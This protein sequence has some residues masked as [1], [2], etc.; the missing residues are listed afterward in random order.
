[1]SEITGP[2]GGEGRGVGGRANRDWALFEK[3]IYF[4]HG[5]ALKAN[6]RQLELVVVVVVGRKYEVVVEP[7]RFPCVGLVGTSIDLILPLDA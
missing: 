2:L 4:G 1:M 6:E 5:L 3:S 7:Y